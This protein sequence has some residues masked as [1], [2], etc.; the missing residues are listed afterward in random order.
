VSEPI[1]WT[2]AF[3]DRPAPEF[4][5]ACDFWTAVTATKLSETRG[6]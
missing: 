5:R 1:R 6:R 4:G 3:V 2:Y